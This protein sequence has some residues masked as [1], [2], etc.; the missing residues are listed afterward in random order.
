MGD[1]ARRVVMAASQI[2]LDEAIS[3]VSDNTLQIN[4]NKLR[5][6]SALYDADFAWFR[7]RLGGVS[8]F[9]GKEDLNAAGRLRT[10]LEVRFAS[11]P[12]LWHFWKNARGFHE[13]LRKYAEAH[14]ADPARDQ[15]EPEKWQ[16][17]KD[18]SEWVNL[19][20]LAHTG[21]EAC[22]DFYSLSARA[23][24]AF[25]TKQGTAGLEVTPIVRVQMTAQ[26][27]CRLM[28]S[29]EKII[30]SLRSRHPEIEDE[31]GSS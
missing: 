22:L 9:F 23:L 5:N 8:L 16:A 15:L 27:L 31:D 21:D 4:P 10:R 1:K 28:D 3:V 30:P 29:C 20:Y 7:E 13:R 17:A 24:A 14:P 25:L 2:Q 19:D 12:F 11:A 6:P 18:H 26:E